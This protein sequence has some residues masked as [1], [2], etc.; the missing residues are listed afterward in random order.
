MVYHAHLPRTGMNVV[1]AHRPCRKYWPLIKP[2]AQLLEG[3]G[4]VKEH[5]SLPDNVLTVLSGSIL[6]SERG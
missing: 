4:G 5:R 2:I 6:Y 3:V 1:I